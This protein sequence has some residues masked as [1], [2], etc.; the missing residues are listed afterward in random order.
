MPRQLPASVPDFT[1]RER[2]TSELVTALTRSGSDAGVAAI[3]ICG[4]PGM[5]KTTLALRVAH[6]LRHR[7]PDGQLWAHLAGAS[8]HARDPGEVLGEWLRALGVQ[9]C[10]IPASAAE[11]AALYRSE[12]AD[13][14][15]LLVADDAGS[16]AQVRPLL[17]G[18]GRSAILVSSRNQLVGL[19]GA[20]FLVLDTFTPDEALRLLTQMTGEKRVAAEPDA[21]GELARA[22]GFMPLAVR[23]A[24]ARLAARPAWPVSLLS[25]KITQERRRLDELEAEDLSVRASVT[26]SYD[27]LGEQAQRAF[28]LLGLL[29]PHD[30][31]EWVI[32]ALLCCSDAAV[33]VNEL[34]EKSLLTSLG[35]DA[36][37]QPRYRLHDLLREYARERAAEEPGQER[38]AAVRR[39]LTGWLQLADLANG[40]IPFNPFFP[41]SPPLLEQ[42]VVPGALAEQLTA[43]PLAWFSAERLNLLEA[44]ERAG[45]G[46]WPELAG[47]LAERQVNFQYLQDRIDEAAQVWGKVVDHA[48][49]AGGEIALAHS[50]LRYAEA[51]ISRGH[52]ADASSLVEQAVQELK[53]AGD[54]DGVSFAVYWQATVAYQLGRHDAAI[55][56]SQR[57]IELSREVGNRHAEFLNLRVFSQTLAHVG[58]GTAAIEACETAVSIARDFAQETYGLVATHTLAFVYV[59]AGQPEKAVPLCQELFERS[60]RQANVRSEGLSLGVLGDAYY[61]L[62]RYQDAAE[63]LSEAVPIFRDHANGYYH[64]LCLLKLGYA[65]QRMGQYQRAAGYL[66]DSLP[67]FQELRLHYYEQRARATLESCL[68]AGSNGRR[69]LPSTPGKRNIVLGF[70]YPGWQL[71]AQFT[72]SAD[73]QT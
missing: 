20:A 21:A 37:G 18:T 11:R 71:F 7:F 60:R 67:I 50:R 4:Q 2:E 42:P 38:D 55:R 29:G 13:R 25:G 64:G 32:A 8:D 27:S 52:A 58:R 17:P 23:I 31:A 9:G 51:L 39:A 73:R 46:P 15:V 16:S 61:G 66:K 57:G 53:D 36:T 65:Y 72:F 69:R 40:M 62:G 5:G 45:D 49:R 6:S 14:Q 43:D 22:C 12:L 24:G 1:G 63:V 19:P 56:Y 10:A 54:K 68:A 41:P 34:V 70:G 26:L 3:V 44:V 47:K 35:A 33:V 59:L 30:I 48:E 28:R